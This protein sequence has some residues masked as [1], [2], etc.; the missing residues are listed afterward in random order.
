MKT[1]EL[2]AARS[3]ISKVSAKPGIG[4]DQRDQLLKAKREFDKIAQSGKL[5]RARVFRATEL[6]CTVL[7][8]IV[9]V[10]DVVR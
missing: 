10:D 7:L 2:N 4:P 8:E 3:L 1:K 6:I 5:D 9:E